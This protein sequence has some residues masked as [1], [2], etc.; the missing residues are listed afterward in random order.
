M[1]IL[2]RQGSA[3]KRAGKGTIRAKNTEGEVRKLGIEAEKR[4][5]RGTQMPRYAFPHPKCEYAYHLCAEMAP[6]ETE[7]GKGVGARSQMWT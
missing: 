3:K 7:D 4:Q 6:E 1:S 2:R 5:R